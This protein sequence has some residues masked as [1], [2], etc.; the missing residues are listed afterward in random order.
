MKLRRMALED[1]DEVSHMEELIFT[2]P[3]SSNSFYDA[4]KNRNMLFVVSEHE[5]HILGYCGMQFVLDEG[6][7]TNVAVEPSYQKQGIGEKM[8]TYLLAE[9]KKMEVT[10]IVL[11]VRVS[12]FHA[13][14]LYE[15]L[16]FQKDGIRKDLYEKPLEDGYIMTLNQ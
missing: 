2:M 7:I 9:A 13:I 12:N 16:G 11:E 3:W 4:V 8:L 5:Q 6:E 15:K 14:H 1:I 10:K